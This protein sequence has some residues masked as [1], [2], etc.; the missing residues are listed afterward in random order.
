MKNIFYVS[1]VQSL[2]FPQN[3]RSKFENYIDFQDLNYINEENIE[4]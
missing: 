2:L 4:I 3:T 1:N